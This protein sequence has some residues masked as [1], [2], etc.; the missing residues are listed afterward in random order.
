LF[1]CAGCGFTLHFNPACAAGAF[2]SAPDG[3]VLFV[4]RAREPARGTLALPGGF[5]DCHERAEEALQRE[6][7]EEVGLD[8]GPL[9]FLCS[10]RND[11]EYREVRYPVVDLFF[12]ATVDQPDHARAL[13]D[14]AELVWL[15]PAS[16]RVEQLAFRSIRAAFQLYAARA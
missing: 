3:R 9:R 16:V 8:V 13:D 11:Y 6:V 7:L 2:L 14:V 5:I 4:R 1:G 12:C 10:Q 15:Q